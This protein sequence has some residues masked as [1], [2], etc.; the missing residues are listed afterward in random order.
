MASLRTLLDKHDQV[1][2]TELQER[3]VIPSPN[4]G[5]QWTHVAYCHYDLGCCD[6]YGR[7]RI[8]SWCVPAGTTKVTFHVWGAGG[9]G[10]G[11]CCCQQGTPG[12]SGAYA[13]VT[14]DTTPGDC[15][16]LCAG[17]N[18][19]CCSRTCLG[20]RGC[21]SY[22]QGNGLINFCADGGQ[23]GKACCFLHQQAMSYCCAIAVPGNQYGYWY[24]NHTPCAF[25]YGADDGAWGR[26]GFTY[27][28][29]RYTDNSCWWKLGVPYPGG[30]HNKCGGHIHVRTSG[31]A[32]ISDWTS[33]ATGTVGGS[34]YSP[35]PGVGGIPATSCAGGCCHAWSGTAWGPGMV[36]IDY[37]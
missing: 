4:F 2:Y 20:C 30:I 13:K 27:A 26:P 10:P 33:C 6:A 8:A 9:G 32:C 31:N 5:C 34:Y 12:G 23:G 18:G 37:C 14:I 29:C 19:L 24:N 35:F 11:A 7:G 25:F 16:T 21:Q 17:M 28:Y 36:K 3:K 15:Y 22:V 1:T